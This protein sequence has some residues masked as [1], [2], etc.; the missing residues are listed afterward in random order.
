MPPIAVQQVA[1]GRGHVAQLLRGTG[2]DRAAE[3]RIARLDLRVIGEIAVGHQRADPQAAVASVLDLVERQTRDVDQPR[4]ARDVLLHQVDQIGAAGDEFGGRV[5]RDPAHRVGDVAGA[6]I[7]EIVHRPA[8][9]G[10]SPA[11]P[12]STASIAATMLG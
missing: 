5:G 9:P 2:E 7:F 1:A 8:S 4:R 10:F 6:R 12:D 3:Q 11:L